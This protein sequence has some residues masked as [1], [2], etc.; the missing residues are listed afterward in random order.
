MNGEYMSCRDFIKKVYDYIGKKKETDILE[1][2]YIEDWTYGDVLK[3]LT[4]NLHDR[5]I[6]DLDVEY[7]IEFYDKRG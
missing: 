5:N 3:V 4:N 2:E 1:I 7:V 6:L